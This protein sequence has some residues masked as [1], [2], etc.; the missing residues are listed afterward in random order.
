MK[1]MVFDCNLIGGWLYAFGIIDMR[2][3][4]PLAPRRSWL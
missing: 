2:N 4:M 3:V 1:E